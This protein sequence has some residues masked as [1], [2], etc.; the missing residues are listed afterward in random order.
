MDRGAT[1]LGRREAG[2][3]ATRNDKDRS[4]ESAEGQGVALVE[5]EGWPERR[6]RTC[7]GAEGGIGGS[8]G[9]A[10]AATEPALAEAPPV[11]CAPA[12]R[13]AGVRGGQD[14]RAEGAVAGRLTAP[15]AWDVAPSAE[16]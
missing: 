9:H 1:I 14:P 16:G 4:H 2:N 5:R 7:T 3:G 11:A 15:S 12:G 10:G 8:A 6:R 13:W